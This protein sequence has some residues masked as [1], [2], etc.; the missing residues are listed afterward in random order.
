M[1]Q[2]IKTQTGASTNSIRSQNTEA[3]DDSII[4]LKFIITFDSASECV[5]WSSTLQGASDAL[6]TDGYSRL[7]SWF[8]LQQNNGGTYKELVSAAEA[9]FGKVFLTLHK[10]VFLQL[11]QDMVKF[12]NNDLD[13]DDDD[14]N[15]SL[16]SDFS[17]SDFGNST[18]DSSG[19]RLVDDI[20]N[21]DFL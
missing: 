14:E 11:Y 5:R 17:G 10:G 1:K 2:N 18:M 15:V 9:K 21:D 7:E 16:E 12:N 19:S 20:M 3:E 4:R 8:M 6:S 13:D